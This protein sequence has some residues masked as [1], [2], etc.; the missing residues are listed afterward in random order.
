V[1]ARSLVIIVRARQ[2]VK[3]NIVFGTVCKCVCIKTE[4]ELLIRS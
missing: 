3:Q 1:S 4:K 2:A